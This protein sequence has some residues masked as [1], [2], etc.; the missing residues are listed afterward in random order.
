MN[1]D[2][3]NDIALAARNQRQGVKASMPSIEHVR[4]LRDVTMFSTS[5][6]RLVQ[7]REVREAFTKFADVYDGHG[8][9]RRRKPSWQGAFWSTCSTTRCWSDASTPFESASSKDPFTSTDSWLY[10]EP[11]GS[12]GAEPVVTEQPVDWQPILR[13]WS[14]SAAML[15]RLADSGSLLKLHVIQPNQYFATARVFSEAEK[16]IAFNPQSPYP[17]LVAEGYPLLIEEAERLSE[18]GVEVIGLL[19]FARSLR[20]ARLRR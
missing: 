7:M 1:I 3:F 10:L 20:S 19:G 8:P 12:R 14:E 16:Q 17:G 2:G 18:G 13:V 4:A 15:Q 11:T 9:A 5:D 6:D